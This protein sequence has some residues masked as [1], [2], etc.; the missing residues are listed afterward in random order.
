MNLL[1]NIDMA[2]ENAN[3][4]GKNIMANFLLRLLNIENKGLKQ[5]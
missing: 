1:A 2:V 3:N 5:V 4:S